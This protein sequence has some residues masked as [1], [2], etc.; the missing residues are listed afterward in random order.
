MAL[1]ASDKSDFP[2]ARDMIAGLLDTSISVAVTDPTLARSA[3]YPEEAAC[4]PPMRALRRREFLAGRD[5]LREAI[6]GLRKPPCAI[7]MADDRSPQLPDGVSAS[8]SHSSDLCVAIADLTSKTSSLGIDIEP[9]EGLEAGLWDTV[10]TRAER[11]WLLTVP[12]P[13]RAVAAKRIFSA[14]ESAYKCQYTFSGA[15]LDYDAFDIT[16]P[17]E[18]RFHATFR[19]AVSPFSIGDRITGRMGDVHGH[20]ICITRIPA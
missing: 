6:A 14:K 7:P 3:V 15:L 10:C 17:A 13:S 12:I 16:F 20:I 2:E 11:A 8:L 1:Q 19:Q 4:L 5:A 9:I 18:D